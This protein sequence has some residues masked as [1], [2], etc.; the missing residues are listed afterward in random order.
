MNAPDS[1]QPKSLQTGAL[2]LRI[3]GF[4]WLIKR[5]FWEHR[6]GLLWAPVLIG[7][8]AL[9]TTVLER[10]FNAHPAQQDSGWLT[11][12]VLGAVGSVAI[13]ALLLPLMLYVVPAFTAF[14]YCIDALQADRRD[15]SI[16]FWKSLP[17]SDAATVLSKAAIALVISPLICWTFYSILSALLPPNL[18]GSDLSLYK[19]FGTVSPW[20]IASLLPLYLLWTLPT[21]GWLLMVSAWARSRPF[22]WA[23]GIPVFVA[24]LIEWSNT[25]LHFTHTTAWVWSDFFARILFSGVFRGWMAPGLGGSQDMVT[26]QGPVLLDNSW[27]ALGM[28]TLWIGAL[29]GIAMI[30]IAIRLRRWRTAD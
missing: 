27:R 23:V 5:E 22:L 26:I 18:P 25:I 7:V 28:P 9:L 1:Q 13:Y 30:A 11:V 2:A 3:K 10:F 17:S 21:V 15:R 19:V 6:R 8:L 29:A 24:G 20:Q 14:F 12:Q 4:Y 16:L